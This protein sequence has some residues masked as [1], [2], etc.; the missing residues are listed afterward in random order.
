MN[1][2]IGFTIWRK[3]SDRIKDL[4]R[5][6]I[7][8][9]IDHVEIDIDSIVELN[10]V[11]WLKSFV[12]LLRDY[13][14]SIGFHA[15]WR[16]LYIASPVESIRRTSTEIIREVTE[17]LD[18]LDIDYKYIVLHGSS[19]QP[20][21]SENTS[22]CLD[23]L[24]RSLEEM[25]RGGS[26]KICIETIQGKC[27]GRLDHIEYVVDRIPEANVCIDLA[28]LYS[29]YY[30]LKSFKTLSDVI[31]IIS[32]KILKR[33]IVIHLHGL[34][35]EGSRF[36]THRTFTHIPLGEVSL[37]EVLKKYN[38]IAFLVFEV[39]YSNEDRVAWPRDV[40]DEIRRIRSLI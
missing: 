9:G 12:R 1:L 3:D 29:E 40:V 21:C 33:S 16:E 26:K 14:L 28:H 2:R 24:V 17:R 30:K 38:N 10:D 31:E 13:N 18:S 7:E 23:S 4:I 37:V 8:T 27:C 6:F 5:D 20:I 36:R 19:E 11:S 34:V 22:V 35:R 25:L 39:F 32:S 15:P